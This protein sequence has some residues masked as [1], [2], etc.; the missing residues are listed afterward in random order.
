MARR[1]HLLTPGR[2][3][4]IVLAAVLLPLLPSVPA[5]DHPLVVPASHG[6]DVAVWNVTAPGRS[7]DVRLEWSSQLSTVLDAFDGEHRVFSVTVTGWCYDPTWCERRVHHFDV[8]DGRSVGSE[9]EWTFD[10]PSWGVL[11]G[12]LPSESYLAVRHDRGFAGSSN[13]LV[14]LAGR[15]LG[16]GEVFVDTPWIGGTGMAWPRTYTALGWEDVEGSTL[17]RIETAGRTLWFDGVVPVPVRT[18]GTGPDG[19]HSQATAR[20]VSF[21]AGATGLE[22]ASYEPPAQG[23]VRAAPRTVFGEAGSPEDWPPAFPVHRA[24]ATVREDPR[25]VAWFLENPEAIVTSA[26]SQVSGGEIVAIVAWEDDDATLWA[27]VLG[28]VTEAGVAAAV[29]QSQATT[30]PHPVPRHAIVG[31]EF[32]CMEASVDVA[33]RDGP[34]VGADT[35]IGRFYLS[36]G[37]VQ[38]HASL[39]AADDGPDDLVLSGERR[40]HGSWASVDGVTGGVH[41]VT[42]SISRGTLNPLIPG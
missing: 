22:D 37:R 6:G 2:L 11:L 33:E 20:L 36:G 28:E 18:E 9:N 40:H 3:V 10:D 21:E 30:F 25:F 29:A 14:A 15:A 19:H 8:G 5:T 23:T 31:H 26:F 24:A 13:A 34:V 17:F 12:E 39:Y 16:P 32:A 1:R 4:P 35:F 27:E 38:C 41:F 42:T 7:W